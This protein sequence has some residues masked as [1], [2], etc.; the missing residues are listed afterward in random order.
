MSTTTA[1]ASDFS[2]WPKKGAKTTA[3]QPFEVDEHGVE[4]TAHPMLTSGSADV[5]AV[6][7]LGR[8]L[9]ELGFENSVSRGENPFGIVDES[10]I[11]AVVQF[12]RQYG[13]REPADGFGGDQVEADRHIGPW[14]ATAIVRASDRLK[15]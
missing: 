9:T 6:T 2:T 11:A 3:T 10:I 7:D 12:R 13:V 14:T 8:R 4:V 5:P 15:S 1:K